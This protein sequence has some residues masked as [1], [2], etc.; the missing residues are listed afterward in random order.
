MCDASRPAGLF[1]QNRGEGGERLEHVSGITH[2]E[3]ARSHTR[4]HAQQTCDLF[5]GALVF[6]VRACG[7][8]VGRAKWDA[9]AYFMHRTMEVGA[10]RGAKHCNTM[11]CVC[12]CACSNYYNWNLCA[13]NFGKSLFALG[14]IGSISVG[15][16]VCRFVSLTGAPAKVH[17]YP[18]DAH[19]CDPHFTSGALSATDIWPLS[20]APS[21]YVC[22]FVF[23]CVCEPAAGNLRTEFPIPAL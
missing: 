17:E 20:I 9:P 8:C 7:H 19:L 2:R 14:R 21:G 4:T 13:I 12:V 6:S 3:R 10:L 15:C 18:S 11:T 23:V 5:R 22:W 16:W 1:W